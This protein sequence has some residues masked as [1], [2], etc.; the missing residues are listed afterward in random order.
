MLYADNPLILPDTMRRLLER[1][2]AGDAGWRCWRS[3]RPIP[4]AMAGSFLAMA[5]SQRIVEWID[6]DDAERARPCAMLACCAGRRPTWR[7]G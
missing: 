2:A 5:M 4:D 6:A 7:A 1:R 3:A